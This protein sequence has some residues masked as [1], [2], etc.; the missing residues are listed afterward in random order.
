MY[1]GFPDGHTEYYDEHEI[2]RRIVNPDR[3]YAE[4]NSKGDLIARFDPQGH[5][6][7][8]EHIIKT[9]ATKTPIV[10]QAKTPARAPLAETPKPETPAVVAAAETT[11]ATENPTSFSLKLGT[12]GNPKNLEKFFYGMV[13]KTDLPEGGNVV[14]DEQI[15]AATK[16]LNVAA[17]L[18]KLTEGHNVAGVS[19]EDFAKS[20]EMKDGTLHVTDSVKFNEIVE[21]LKT[22]AQENWDKGILQSKGAAQSYVEKIHDD[23]RISSPGAH[24]AGVEINASTP[25]D[26]MW[27]LPMIKHPETL[28]FENRPSA[29]INPATAQEIKEKIVAQMDTAPKAPQAVETPSTGTETIKKAIE[30]APKSMLEQTS[31][32]QQHLDFVGKNP[33]HLTGEKMMHAYEVGQK[34]VAHLFQNNDHSLGVWNA[35]KNAKVGNLLKMKNT[36]EDDIPVIKYIQKLK[37]ITKLN[38]KNG[39][40]GIQPETVDHYIARALQK[41]ALLGKLEQVELK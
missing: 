27:P 34:N 9:A 1:K 36:N 35:I 22:H 25:A 39:I 26:V 4:Y 13:N 20:F 30:V 8:T 37:D 40:L 29:P 32:I 18:V 10:E 16:S 41:A 24:E 33:F 2:L 17:N 19:A 6:I 28:I 7:Q 23:F 14:G 15:A 5:K 12:E 21:H 38:P 11:P 31:F 3:S